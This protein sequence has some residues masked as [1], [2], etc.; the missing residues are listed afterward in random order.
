MLVC[1][2][3]EVFGASYGGI[4]AL[5][6][7]LKEGECALVLGDD[8]LPVPLVYIQRVEVVELFVGTD[9]AHVGV[10]AVARMQLILGKCNALPLGKRVYHL[11]LLVAEVLYGEC[12][13]TLHTIEV[14]IDAESL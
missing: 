10:H 11:C 8:S 4:Y 7:V 13:R 3:H 6:H 1:L 14:V 9:G 2:A 12:N 5:H